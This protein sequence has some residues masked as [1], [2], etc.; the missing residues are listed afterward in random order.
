[1][2]YLLSDS[3]VDGR[4]AQIL[5]QRAQSHACLSYAEIPEQARLPV[6]FRDNIQHAKIAEKFDPKWS[7]KG[8]I[9]ILLQFFLNHFPIILSVATP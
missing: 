7:K 6:A 8:I 3:V 1:M 5:E 2:A 4:F 9:E